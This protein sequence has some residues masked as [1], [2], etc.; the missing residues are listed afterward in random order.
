MLGI[1][2]RLDRIERK[3]DRHIAEQNGHAERKWRGLSFTQWV[4]TGV[5]HRPAARRTEWSPP[6][7]PRCSMRSAAAD[8]LNA[9]AGR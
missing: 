6:G 4:L 2:K 3:L 5:D 1:T 8:T 7:L 9:A